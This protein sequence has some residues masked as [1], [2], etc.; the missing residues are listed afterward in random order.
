MARRR[1]IERS[2]C[3]HWLGLLLIVNTLPLLALGYVGWRVSKGDT[4]WGE[5]L[6]PGLRQHGLWLCIWIAALGLLAWVLMPAAGAGAR[7]LHAALQAAR[8]P[9]RSAGR[10]F[11]D[12]VL[13]LPR[14]LFFFVFFLLRGVF[15]LASLATL[16]LIV[17]S[18]IR[19]AKPE[20]L[21]GI[22]P[23]PDD[24]LALFRRG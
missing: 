18:M 14:Q 24:P 9:G 12:A 20:F 6:P 3:R 5:V 19:L 16:L 15:F 7:R 10:R 4:T 8:A 17:L 11:G 22:P 21:A 13:W 1:R 23:L 2:G